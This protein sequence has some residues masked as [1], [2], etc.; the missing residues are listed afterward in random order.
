M[1]DPRGKIPFQTE[2]I[3]HIRGTTSV[4]NSEGSLE[5]VG[6]KGSNWIQKKKKIRNREG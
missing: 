6:K 1:T 4:G 3:H 5:G 2:D